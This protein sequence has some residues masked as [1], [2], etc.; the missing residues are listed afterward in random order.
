M[1]RREKIR[2]NIMACLPQ[3]AV[4]CM[5]WNTTHRFTKDTDKFDGS[6]ETLCQRYLDGEVIDLDS[7]NFNNVVSTH[8]ELPFKYKKL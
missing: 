5:N 4:I 6:K 2:Q 3:S 7:I 1:N 8:E